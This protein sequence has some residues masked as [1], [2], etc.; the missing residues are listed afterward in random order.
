VA[1]IA[2]GTLVSL[3]ECVKALLRY[4]P[5]EGCEL[6]IGVH[7]GA[8]NAPTHHLTLVLGVI[9]GELHWCGALAEAYCDVLDKCRED[10]PRSP[11]SRA[12]LK[13]TRLW[14]VLRPGELLSAPTGMPNCP[15]Y[16]GERP[17]LVIGECANG[18]LLA[19]PLNDPSNPKWYTPVVE[20][21]HLC[22]D[23]AKRSQVELPH[24]WAFPPPVSAMEGVSATGQ[25]C[26]RPTIER[27]Y[28]P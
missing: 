18:A 21:A 3:K 17:W 9:A 22:F 2:V 11:L 5:P 14:T 19:A 8:L 12:I 4:P 25:A 27:Y 16:R 7:P 26:L 6:R 13:G 24:A 28:A 10:E 20:A 1:T 23:G 15:V